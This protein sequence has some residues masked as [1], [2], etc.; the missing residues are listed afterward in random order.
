MKLLA[1]RLAG[2]SLRLT[3]KERIRDKK[4]KTEAR[5]SVTSSGIQPITK[6]NPQLKPKIS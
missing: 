2:L 3:E 5:V 6:E 4:Y 1:S